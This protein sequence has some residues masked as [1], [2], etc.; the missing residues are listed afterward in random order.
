VRRYERTR[1]LLVGAFADLAARGLLRESVAP[2]DTALRTIA[3]MDGLQLQWL[4][5]P[6]GVDMAHQLRL[7]LRAFT[8]PGI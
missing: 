2:E 7:H 3:V 4:L 5:D 1:Q 8:G 6:G